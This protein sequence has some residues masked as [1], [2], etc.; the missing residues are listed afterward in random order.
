MFFI[1]CAFPALSEPCV[2]CW[3]SISP[4]K[5][6]RN[7]G[8]WKQPEAGW[9]RVLSSQWHVSVICRFWP[10]WYLWLTRVLLKQYHLKK[11]LFP[12]YLY[13]PC[14]YFTAQM[15]TFS[16]PPPLALSARVA[17]PSTW[18]LCQLHGALPVCL[19]RAGSLNSM[20]SPFWAGFLEN[21]L[22]EFLQQ[23]LP[24]YSSERLPLSSIQFQALA[25]VVR[26]GHLEPTGLPSRFS[27]ELWSREGPR[28]AR[29]SVPPGTPAGVAPTPSPAFS[30]RYVDAPVLLLPCQLLGRQRRLPSSAL[31]FH[32]FH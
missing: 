30:K 5:C 29:D 3:T 19:V 17:F 16:F 21:G 10:K 4:L 25:L 7:H 15:P 2:Q 13:Q 11:A 24:P 23:M 18:L 6:P 12:L 9:M 31:S 28:S 27:P 22:Q 8:L 26:P 14:V 32:S 1:P 20:P